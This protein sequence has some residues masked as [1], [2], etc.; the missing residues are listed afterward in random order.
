[1]TTQTRTQI[2]RS[3][4]GNRS[5]DR[6]DGAQVKQFREWEQIV[7]KLLADGRLSER[8]KTPE[9]GVLLMAKAYELG[10]PPIEGLSQLYVVR[11]VVA[12]QAQAMMA[13]AMKSGLVRIKWD[14]Q[15]PDRCKAT[16]FRYSPE[17][18]LLQEYPCEWTWERVQEAGFHKD[19]RGNVKPTYA[20]KSSRQTMIK[21]KCETEGLRTV[22]PDLL[23]G[24]Y[25][26]E[27]FGVQSLDEM[28]PEVVAAG[29]GGHMPLGQEGAD[30]IRQAATDMLRDGVEK[31]DIDTLLKAAKDS[32]GVEY[33]AELTREQGE[34]LLRS[35]AQLREKVAGAAA[36]EDGD[37][38]DGVIE[39]E[40]EAA[41]P[42]P[43]ATAA[44]PEPTDLFGDDPFPVES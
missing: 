7:V 28:T 12:M 9:Q 43:A 37:A 41:V 26:P 36:Q 34:V 31:P 15:S 18:A 42:A 2:I 14:E 16:F 17:G 23:G 20:N 32:A 5:L 3:A 27:E 4:P 25:A 8:I 24:L 10:M 1:M 44:K 30:E 38:D 40:F 33:L 21:H 11:G 35:L 6:R 13:L 22:C 19:G 39:G 29:L